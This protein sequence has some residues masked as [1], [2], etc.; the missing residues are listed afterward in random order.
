M[1]QL[2]LALLCRS[3]SLSLIAARTR[4][5]QLDTDDR[6]GDVIGG[7]RVERFCTASLSSRESS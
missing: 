1:Q 4:A 2:A 7:A 6:L 5:I 3:S